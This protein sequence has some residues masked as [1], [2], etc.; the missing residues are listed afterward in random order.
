M[1]RYGGFYLILWPLVGMFLFA[2]LFFVKQTGMQYNIKTSTMGF[3]PEG[4]L[5]STKPK[6]P[7]EC[8]ILF[9]SLEPYSEDIFNNISFVLSSMSIEYDSIDL[10]SQ[11]FPELSLYR[12]AIMSFANMD[13]VQQFLPD[14]FRW[15]NLGGRLMFSVSIEPTSALPIISSKLGMI[16]SATK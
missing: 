4:A 11:Q 14:L 5:L 7:K 10:A 3:L 2:V 13:T 9:D 1:K 8:I 6:M 12:T 16:E 15:V